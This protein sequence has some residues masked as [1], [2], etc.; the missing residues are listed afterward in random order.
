MTHF[1]KLFAR[2]FSAV[3]VC[4][5]LA[6]SA[7]AQSARDLTELTVDRCLSAQP[8]LEA[9]TD[10]LETLGWQ[11]VPYAELT[12]EHLYNWAAARLKDEL[13]FTSQTSAFWQNAWDRLQLNASGLCKKTDAGSAQSRTVLFAHQEDDHV[14]QLIVENNGAFDQ[15]RCSF[16]V[17]PSFAANSMA[18]AESELTDTMP[19]I[20]AL[21][22]QEF[23][24]EK[25][26]RN[27]QINLF[28][29]AAI[30]DFIGEDFP[31]VA[32]VETQL[33]ILH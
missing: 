6:T 18:S 14:L 24:D 29:R 7:N 5:L 22:P 27:L 33:S 21:K 16:V 8:S 11:R 1:K 3:F 17:R 9:I 20:V 28:R 30:S 13:V 15:S 10:A 31:F 23:G 26:M 32:M 25:V 19:T 4:L 12:D 2:A